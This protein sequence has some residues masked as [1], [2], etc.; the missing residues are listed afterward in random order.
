[1]NP[2]YSYAPD[3]TRILTPVR[4]PCGDCGELRSLFVNREGHTA[5]WECAEKIQGHG[6]AARFEVT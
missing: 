4:I 2:A 5:C 3:A 1:M 6:L